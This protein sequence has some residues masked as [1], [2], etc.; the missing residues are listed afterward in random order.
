MQIRSFSTINQFNDFYW[1][2]FAKEPDI[3]N[4]ADSEFDIKTNS[5]SSNSAYLFEHIGQTGGQI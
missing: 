2:L 5:N 4:L 1:S 3:L